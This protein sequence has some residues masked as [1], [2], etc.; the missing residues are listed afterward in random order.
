MNL[1]SLLDVIA[2]LTWGIVLVVIGYRF[3]RN[4][5]RA[6]LAV[7]FNRSVGFVSLSLLAIAV[8]VTFIS[9]AVIFIE[10]QRRGVVVSALWAGGVQPDAR[11]P[12]ISLI[13]PLAEDVYQYPIFWQ[14]YTMSS[15]PLEGEQ[16]GDD[17]IIAR[18]NDGQEVR[19]DCSII[20]RID[21]E[22]VVR[23]H[24]DW[25]SRYINDLVRPR[26]RGIVRS[27][28]SQFNAIELNSA[29]RSNL[30]EQINIELTN[31]LE[32]QGLQLDAFVLRNV[33]FTPEFAEAVEQKQVAEQRVIEARLQAQQI[34]A[35]ALGRANEARTL[36]QGD[37]DAA[38]TRAQGQADAL[39]TVNTALAQDP[40]TLLTYE[41]IQR[42]APNIRVLLVPNN[43]PLVLPLPPQELSGDNTTTAPGGQAT[44][45]LSD[46]L[47]QVLN[48]VP[49]PA[50]TPA[51]T[52]TPALSATPTP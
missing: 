39:S 44:G 37:A 49:T 23:V 29:S 40:E 7:A 2:T 27:I 38:R 43:A 13:V 33:A 18:T 46:T 21:R 11:E 3:W 26:T 5:R 22:Q 1:D 48:G 45:A 25:Q 4:W 30:E 14:T 31:I 36:A 42:I 24:I 10:P 52:A 16:V 9:A 6:S 15:N 41:Y 28:A 20:F 32:D 47:Q 34:E 8:M 19:L 35:L 12:G 50:A 51:P 17:S